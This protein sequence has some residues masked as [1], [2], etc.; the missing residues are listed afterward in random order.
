MRTQP[1]FCA[2]SFDC[3]IN[4]W[5]IDNEREWGMGMSEVRI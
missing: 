5:N 4:Q 1:D 2:A 3:H